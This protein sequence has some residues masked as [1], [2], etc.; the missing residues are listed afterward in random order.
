M[1]IAHTDE[2]NRV[3][4]IEKYFFFLNLLEFSRSSAFRQRIDGAGN[5]KVI[6]LSRAG[7]FVDITN[8]RYAP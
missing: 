7:V 4:Y 6:S 1:Q 3:K 2:H 8:S 5:F